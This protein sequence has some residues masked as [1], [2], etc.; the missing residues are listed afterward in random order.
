MLSIY[1]HDIYIYSSSRTWFFQIALNRRKTVN[2]HKRKF[3][4]VTTEE[5]NL[6]E[7]YLCH[8][9]LKPALTVVI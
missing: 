5:R 6:F 7:M 9:D 8:L 3:Q 2:E 1:Q 4:K